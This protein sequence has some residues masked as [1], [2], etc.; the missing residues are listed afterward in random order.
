M[1]GRFD[2]STTPATLRLGGDL[3][4][5]SAADLQAQLLEAL[6]SGEPTQVE[7][8]AITE[9]DVTGLQLLTAAERAAQARG[10]AW[11]RDGAMPESLRQAAEDAGWERIPF[12]GDVQ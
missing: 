3:A 9:V 1:K 6:A 7:L 2:R 10:V 4:I 12:A 11:I 5:D 8:E